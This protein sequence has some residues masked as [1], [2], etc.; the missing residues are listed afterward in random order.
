M[1]RAEISLDRD[2]LWEM[3]ENNVEDCF[4]YKIEDEN[5]LNSEGVID[6]IHDELSSNDVAS[7]ADV[8]DILGEYDF[9]QQ[10]DYYMES[11]DF[12]ETFQQTMQEYV[13]AIEVVTM[14]DVEEL[15]AQVDMLMDER[16]ARIDARLSNRLRRLWTRLK[17]IHWYSPFMPR[18]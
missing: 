5:L 6:L 7:S 10:F 13:E 11:Y 4:T 8:Y 3:I 14:S 18:R 9:S 17:D 2:G 12:G 15:R 16:A 1:I